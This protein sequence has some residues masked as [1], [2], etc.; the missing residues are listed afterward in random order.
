MSLVVGYIRC[1]WCP[2]EFVGVSEVRICVPWHSSIPQDSVFVSSLAS[3]VRIR[4]VIMCLACAGHAS[5]VL[6]SFR[7]V[8]GGGT[9]FYQSFL[10]NF[11]SPGGWVVTLIDDRTNEHGTPGQAGT[12]HT[13]GGRVAGPHRNTQLANRR[14]E[15]PTNPGSRSPTTK[16]GR[17]R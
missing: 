1:V 2:M 15:H 10:S 17:I 13:L 16:S 4:P 3:K 6:G 11:P 5:R 14:S 12:S 7:G 8:R 9:L